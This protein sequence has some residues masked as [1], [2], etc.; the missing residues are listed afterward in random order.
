MS[1]LSTESIFMIGASIVAIFIVIGC[2]TYQCLNLYCNNQITIEK[3]RTKQLHLHYP[4]VN[5]HPPLRK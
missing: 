2:T 5:N 4:P 3:E 1:K